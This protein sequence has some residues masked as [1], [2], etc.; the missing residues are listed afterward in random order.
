M[1]Q[2]KPQTYHKIY[3]KIYINSYLSLYIYIKKC[4]HNFNNTLIIIVII[5]KK[6]SQ[7]Y[8]S[9]FKNSS[10]YVENNSINNIIYIK[11]K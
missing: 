2:K 1:Q 11:E 5:I 9:M 3:T 4:Q 10:V 6:I 8:W 7:S